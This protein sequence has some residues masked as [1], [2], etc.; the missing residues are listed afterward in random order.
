MQ[1]PKLSIL[2]LSTHK[3]EKWL[4][5]IEDVLSWQIRHFCNPGDV[6]Y[7]LEIDGGAKTIG[8]KRNMAMSKANGIAVAYLDEDDF[9][10]DQYIQRGIQFAESDKDV[11]TLRG[12]YFTNG[13]YDRPFEHS[14]RYKEWS[15][16]SSLYR[17]CPNHINFI[18]R[19]LI[20]DIPFEHK[21]FGEDGTASLLWRDKGIFKTEF[22]IPETLYFYFARSKNHGE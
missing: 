17:R 7:V 18:K 19:D 6:Q 14:L 9:I 16:D 15:Q 4:E 20:K 12:L 10:G 22:E 13:V 5:R 1:Q 21:N 3:R 2:V 11:A 8:E